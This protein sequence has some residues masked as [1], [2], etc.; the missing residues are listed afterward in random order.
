MRFDEIIREMEAFQK[1]VMGSM[2]EDF[3]EF[4]PFRSLKPFEDFKSLDDDFFGDPEKWFETLKSGKP[5]G[6]W[7]FERID[8]PGVKGFIARGSFSMPGIL[9][10]PEEILPPIKPQADE[11]RRPLYDIHSDDNSLRIY[12]ELPGV[13]ED[14]IDLKF[15]D[16]K[17]RLEAGDFKEEIDLSRWILD[18]DKMTKEYRNGILNVSIPREDLKEQMV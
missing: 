15:E 12:V 10:R 7:Q 1:K 8:Q 2:F 18:A 14:Q 16:R 11:P 17:L 9:K 13:E 6:E 4:R 3:Q 5:E